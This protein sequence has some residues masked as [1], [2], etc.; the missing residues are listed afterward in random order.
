[1]AIKRIKHLVESW[2][3]RLDSVVFT[4]SIEDTQ[5]VADSSTI[6][7]RRFI[8]CHGDPIDINAIANVRQMPTGEYAG[9]V[10]ASFADSANMDGNGRLRVAN[11]VNVFLNKNI[12]T[13][14]ETLWEEPMVGAIIEHGSVTS[15]PFQVGE[16]IT[17]GASG[18]TAV[19]TIVTASTVSYDINHNDFEDG[20]TITGGTSGATA[21]VT[22]HNT[23]SDIFHNRNLASSVIQIGEVIGDKASRQTHRYTP[24]V[25]GKNHHITETFV[26]TNGGGDVAVVRRTST[27]GDVVNNAIPQSEWGAVSASN[28]N[29][30]GDKLDGS[31]K[32][33]ITLDMSKDVYFVIDFVW[34]G[35]GRVRWG[36]E[37]FGEVL[38]FHE[39]NFTNAVKAMRNEAASLRI[40]GIYIS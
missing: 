1:M 11:P 26:T 21:T 3:H 32:S 7:A 9:R 2:F 23:G 19:L 16:T 4:D 27:S 40:L 6:T 17:G 10:E 31:G 33:G 15:G 5:T 12:H 36:L 38:Y 24:Y 25:P 28:P 39:E 14:N 18:A 22:T 34:Q 37:L 13:D 35:A 8:A 29:G 20:E 30:N